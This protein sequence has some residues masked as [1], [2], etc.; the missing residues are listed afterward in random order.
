MM[1]NNVYFSYLLYP[2]IY[3]IKHIENVPMRRGYF[4][5]LP[6]YVDAADIDFLPSFFPPFFAFETKDA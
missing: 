4:P 3:H 5:T 1:S 6:P 2:G